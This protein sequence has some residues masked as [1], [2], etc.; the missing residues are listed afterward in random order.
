MSDS[1]WYPLQL[2][3]YYLQIYAAKTKKKVPMVAK[4]FDL[5][6]NTACVL[7]N[8]FYVQDHRL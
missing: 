2:C 3:L 4:Y 7:C 8:I 5:V 1:Q 6:Y